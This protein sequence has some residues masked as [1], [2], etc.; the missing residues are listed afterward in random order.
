M[1]GLPYHAVEQCGREHSTNETHL[2]SMGI[3]GLVEE[4]REGAIQQSPD[5]GEV[6]EIL[7][8]AFHLAPAHFRGHVHPTRKLK[9]GCSA[10]RSM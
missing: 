3:V 9:D 10:T 1:L 8:Q 6:L 7:A 2:G 5:S 4:L